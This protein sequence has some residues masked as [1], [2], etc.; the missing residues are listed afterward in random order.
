MTLFERL[1]SRLGQL[2]AYGGGGGLSM[3]SKAVAA[4]VVPPNPPMSINEV[5]G[6]GG[7]VLVTIRLAFDIYVYL[8]KRRRR[9]KE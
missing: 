2:I 5:I 4:A 9:D 8:D 3:Y 1:H 6:I 7:L